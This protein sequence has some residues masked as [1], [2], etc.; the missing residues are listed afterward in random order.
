VK[1][2][3][4]RHDARGDRADRGLTGTRPT[5]RDAA[6]HGRTVAFGKVLQRHRTDRV[7]DVGCSGGWLSEVM[8]EGSVLYGVDIPPGHPGDRLRTFALADG[9]ALPFADETFDAVVLLEVIEHVPANTEPQLLTEAHRVLRAGGFV[10]LSTPNQ[11]LVARLMD[12]A[13][14][15]SGHRH[16]SAGRVSEMLVAAGFRDPAV[17]VT[18]GTWTTLYFPLFCVLNRLG[19]RVPFEAAWRRLITRELQRPGWHTVLAETSK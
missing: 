5:Y 1:T 3:R 12:P 8:P 10:L 19:G 15:L 13:W 4:L 16:Y 6:A 9:R 7:L 17:S 18:G 11:H 14:W 2:A